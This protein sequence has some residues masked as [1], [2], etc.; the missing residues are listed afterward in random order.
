[1]EGDFEMASEGEIKKRGFGTA[2]LHERD[3]VVEG[4]LRQQRLM[5]KYGAR[6]ESSACTLVVGKAVDGKSTVV[7]KLLN[8]GGPLDSHLPI[9]KKRPVGKD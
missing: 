8:F 6:V 4:Q 5:V 2:L 7:W 1:M 3:N 9:R